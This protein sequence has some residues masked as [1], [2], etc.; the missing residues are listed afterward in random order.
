LNPDLPTFW[1][2]LINLNRHLSINKLKERDIKNIKWFRVIGSA[3]GIYAASFLIITI[4][5]TIYAF[6]LAF[7]ARGKPDQA[8]IS[9]FAGSISIWLM[10][11]LE[12]VFTFLAAWLVTKKI[13]QNIPMH[14]ILIGIAAGLLTIALGLILHGG[15]DY[16]DIVFFFIFS[17]LGFLG[18]YVRQRRTTEKMKS[19]DSEVIQA[20]NAD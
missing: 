12:S 14:G 1:R 2:I 17:A 20:K 10:P 3:F 16:L 9:Q 11:L 15:F 19:K 6:V 7:E 5:T 18:G 13:V 4:I 8:A